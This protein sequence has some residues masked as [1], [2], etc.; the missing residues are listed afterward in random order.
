MSLY[1]TGEYFLADFGPLPEASE[2]QVNKARAFVAG[3]ARDAE[4]CA[5]LLDMLGLPPLEA[6]E[7]TA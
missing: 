4:D 3:Q 1:R 6:Q 5:M 2:E 7:K